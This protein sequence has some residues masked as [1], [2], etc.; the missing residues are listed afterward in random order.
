MD[1]VQEGYRIDSDSYLYYDR[2][3]LGDRVLDIRDKH[4]ETIVLIG[5]TIPSELMAGLLVFIQNLFPE[6]SHTDSSTDGHQKFKCSHLNIYN[7]YA[8]RGDDAP[9]DAD[10]WML[11][12]E[13]K[14]P[15]DIN[16]FTPR[17]SAEFYEQE[18]RG[19][20][21]L[22]AMK[23]LLTYLAGVVKDRF[24]KENGEL[25]AFISGLPLNAASPVHPWGG[26]AVNLNAAT[27]VHLDPK[28]LN[29]CLVLAIHDCTGGELVLEGPGIVIKLKSGDF[30]IF[31]SKRYSHYNLDFKGLR[32]SFAFSTDNAAKQWIED[33]NGWL[34]NIH[35]KSSRT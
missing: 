3:Q 20:R 9:H 10:P 19:T 13:G 12:K 33:N 4:G 11:E 5:C 7:R 22:T 17:F 25:V 24:P 18:T 6:L 1:S 15:P 21:L 27:I 31:P 29:L 28:D 14:R 30:T 26:V 34:R 23:P 8:T 35:M 32:V 2:D 16:Q